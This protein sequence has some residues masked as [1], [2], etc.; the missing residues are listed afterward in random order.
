MPFRSSANPLARRPRSAIT[1]DE[2]G[3]YD[4]RSPKLWPADSSRA[5]P[6][7]LRVLGPPGRWRVVG[8]RGI[9]NVMPMEGRMDDTMAVT[10]KPDSIGDWDIELEYVGAATISPRGERGS[11]GTPYR[12]LYTRFEPD[13]NWAKRFYK[14]SDSTGDLRKAPA[15]PLA[16]ATATPVL[17]LRAPRLDFQGYRA[18]RPDLPREF[19]AVEATGTVD[20]PPGEYTLR[21]ISDDGIRVWVDS[22]LV[23]DNWTPHE[24]ALDFA[25]LQGGRHNIRVQYYQADGWYEFRLDIVRGRD[26]SPGSP[27]AHGLD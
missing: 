8:Q 19:F 27:G 9:A 5:M 16:F 7:R 21:T 25:T 2:W 17:T 12:F 1:V 13:I 26:R 24:S 11:A 15:S 14:W 3:P 6:L 23:I 10:P 22:A 4:W 18:F 20:L